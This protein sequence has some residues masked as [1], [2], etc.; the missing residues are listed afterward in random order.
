MPL[1]I[2]CSTARAAET[3]HLAGVGERDDPL[4]RWCPCRRC[5]C[6]GSAPVSQST[7]RR[8]AT[9]ARS[10]ASRQASSAASAARKRWFEFMA[11]SSSASKERVASCVRRPAAR[12][13]PGSRSR[14]RPAAARGGCRSGPRA[15]RRRTSCTPTPFGATTP[16][17]VTTTRRSSPAPP[18]RRACRCSTTRRRPRG[19]LD[20]G[21]QLPAAEED[22]ASADRDALAGRHHAGELDVRVGED[23]DAPRCGLV[24]RRLLASR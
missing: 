17:P 21:A 9:G 5:R 1:A 18:C 11:C 10:P 22:L 16:S 7:R 4:A 13:P 23:A 3:A 20:R 19:H 15:A 24:G 12:P 6:R 14:A 2:T 8:R